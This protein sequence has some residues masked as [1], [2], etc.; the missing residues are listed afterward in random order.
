MIETASVFQRRIVIGAGFCAAAF[1][2]VGV[3]LIDVTL[4]KSGAA[5]RMRA[6]N[7]P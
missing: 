5:V 2:L 7:A 1:A 6:S 3:R 4:M